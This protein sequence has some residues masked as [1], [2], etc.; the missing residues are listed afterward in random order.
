MR[1]FPTTRGQQPIDRPVQMDAPSA[2]FSSL[3]IKAIVAAWRRRGWNAEISQTAGT[4]VC[5]HLFYALM[6]E[7]A[8]QTHR[9]GGF[10]HVPTPRR[11]LSMNTMEEAM[12][13]MI[14]ISLR[15][16]PDL[17]QTAGRED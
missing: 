1:A 17:S 2:Y 8:G 10:V 13:E 4:Y 3:P 15:R 9:R 16:R 11:G 14:K 6:H 7:L 5:N 12:R